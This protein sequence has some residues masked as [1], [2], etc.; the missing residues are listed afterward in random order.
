ML[1]CII[2]II[3]IY[4]SGKDTTN[5]DTIKDRPADAVDCSSKSNTS[6]GSTSSSGSSNSSRGSNS[7][8]SPK[9]KK[10]KL[11]EMERDLYDEV[12][13]FIASWFMLL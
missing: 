13:I 3:M 11:Y 12:T 5:I 2:I 7:K 6:S 8:T 10:K 9:I 4:T 1:I